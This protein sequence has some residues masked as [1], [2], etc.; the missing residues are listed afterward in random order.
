MQ[1][2]KEETNTKKSVKFSC[3]DTTINFI[4]RANDTD[5]LFAMQ[6]GLK[7]ISKKLF[8]FSRLFAVGVLYTELNIITAALSCRAILATGKNL[9]LASSF[10]QVQLALLM[11][12]PFLLSMKIGNG[13][14]LDFPLFYY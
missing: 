10:T 14:V 1:K 5:E 8:F 7:S 2:V 9:F 12:F 13:M 3:E 11:E 4:R 6:E